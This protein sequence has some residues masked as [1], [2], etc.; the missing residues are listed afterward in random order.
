MPITRA[1]TLVVVLAS[2]P[3][4]LQ[5]QTIDDGVMM[6]KGALFAGDLYTHDSWDRYWEGAL[7]RDN[8]NIGRL[9]TRTNSWFGNYGISDR[10]NVIGTVPYVWTRASQGVLHGMQGVQ[11]I[12][13]AG[14]YRLL[15]RGSAKVGLLRAIAVVA[16]ALPLTDYTPDFYPLSIGSASR[17]ASGRF[18][19][20]LQSDPGW[21]V[22]GSMAYPWRGAHGGRGGRARGD[23]L[24]KPREPARPPMLPLFGNVKGWMMTP[25]DIVNSD[26][27]HRRQPRRA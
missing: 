19:V 24:E 27:Q 21:Y 2:F 6:R 16:A 12:T 22:N 15:E 18:T 13:L 3:L 4:S 26:L 14:K 5:A 25:D 8:G 10:L 11:D 23:T 9:T 17:R 20:N 7:K 1:L